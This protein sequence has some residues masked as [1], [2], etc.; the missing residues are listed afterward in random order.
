M[1][2]WKVRAHNGQSRQGRGQVV[3]HVETFTDSI[4]EL[5]EGSDTTGS[6]NMSERGL[7]CERRAYL[8]GRYPWLARVLRP[9][10][11]SL[12]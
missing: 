11:E 3:L 9:A 5:F 2:D 6:A 8:W 1:I 4:D 12:V 7:N 10:V